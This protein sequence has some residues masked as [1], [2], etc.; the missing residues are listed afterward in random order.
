[1]DDDMN[2][3]I[4]DFGLARIVRGGNDDEANTKRVVGT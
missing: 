4:S 2:P 1:L 3:K